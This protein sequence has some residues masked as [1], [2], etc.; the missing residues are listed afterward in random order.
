[1]AQRSTYASDEVRLRVPPE[2]R[3]GAEP[4]FIDDDPTDPG[5]DRARG[6]DA[7]GVDATA[8]GAAVVDAL[9]AASGE[10]PRRPQEDATEATGTTPAGPR[11]PG[12]RQSPRQRQQVSDATYAARST[13]VVFDERDGIRRTLTALAGLMLVAAVGAGVVA[14]LERTQLTLVTAATMAVLA[15]VVWGARIAA[16]PTRVQIRHG[17]LEVRRPG[18]VEVADLANARTPIAVVG[19][20]SSKRWRVL[21]ERANEPLLVVDGSMVDPDAFTD[22]LYHVHPQLWSEP[23]AVLEPWQLR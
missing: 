18:R 22:V 9:R 12:R 8:S 5:L 20:T 4:Q 16:T 15:L 1:M 6:R 10:P 7:D 14:Y 11:R 13:D 2:L 19:R 3:R 23:G 21:I 17:Q